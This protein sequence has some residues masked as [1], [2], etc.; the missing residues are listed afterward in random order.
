MLTDDDRDDFIRAVELI[1]TIVSRHSTDVSAPALVALQIA[2]HDID[3]IRKY[4]DAVN[5]E[6][7]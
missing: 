5:T 4:L 2:V 6:K 7:C 3:V 1:Q